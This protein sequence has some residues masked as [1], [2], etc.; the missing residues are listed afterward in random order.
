V[1]GGTTT[2]CL[3]RL[4]A[5]AGSLAWVASTAPELKRRFPFAACFCAV[6]DTEFFG[7]ALSFFAFL[8]FRFKPSP[9]KTKSSRYQSTAGAC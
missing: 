9:P 2:A 1:P 8:T 4:D 7:G 6:V 3:A 5:P